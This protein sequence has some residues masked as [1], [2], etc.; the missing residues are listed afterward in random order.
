MS[1][2]LK[3]EGYLISE[4]LLWNKMSLQA[5][6]YKINAWWRFK[7]NHMHISNHSALEVNDLPLKRVH[8]F[9]THTAKIYRPSPTTL[10]IHRKTGVETAEQLKAAVAC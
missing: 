8:F 3:R 9:R 6:L 5:Y 10:F 2:I 1:N 4:V 7:K